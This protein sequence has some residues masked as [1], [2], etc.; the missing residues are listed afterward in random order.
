MSTKTCYYETLGVERQ[1]DGATIKKAYRSLALK[2]HPDRNPGDAEAEAKFREAAE[3]YEVLSNQEKRQMYDQYGHEGLNRAGFQGGFQDFGDIF[4]AFGNIFGDF[5]SGASSASQNRARR[6]RDLVYEAVIEFTEA[7]TGTPLELKI[8]R[9]ETCEAC[10]GSG[11]KSHSRS[12]CQ[13]C[14][15]SGQVYQGR[16][17]IRMASV[18]PICRGAGS[19]VT[20]PCD[21][22][23]GLGRIKRTKTLSVKVPAGVDTGSRMRLS[24]EGESG[25]NGGPPGDLYVELMVRHHEYFS[26][27]HNHVLLERKIDL[28]TAALGADLDVPT[29]TGE[30]K[31]LKIPAGSQNGKLLRLSG[32][33]FRNPTGG[34]TGDLIVSLQVTTPQDLTE[35]QEE[36]LREF[37]RLEDAKRGESPIRRLAK[38]ASRKLRKAMACLSL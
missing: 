1:A 7:F 34:A 25:Y 2:Y 17:F 3:A 5:F 20:D 14:G 13:Q 23:R 6:G 30:T 18:C 29:V 35:R 28:V 16:G 31:T 21:Q 24:G 26:R 9:E 37:A 10:D 12:T 33:G 22:C 38:K 11:S 32:L 19:I 27:E 8:P 15:G 36:L 4:S